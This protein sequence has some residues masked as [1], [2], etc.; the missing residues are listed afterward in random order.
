MRDQTCIFP[1]SKRSLAGSA[2]STKLLC[3]KQRIWL[4]KT[5]FQLR[6]EG[7]TQ[8]RKTGMT[9]QLRDNRERL[10]T[11]KKDD[12]PGSINCFSKELNIL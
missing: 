1:Q 3:R 12:G 5:V 8:G 4:G 10:R 7:M 9:V 11:T 6:D 2:A